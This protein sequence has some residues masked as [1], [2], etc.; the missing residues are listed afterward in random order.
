MKAP[1]L[2]C[3]FLLVY[4]I[5]F[6]QS[7]QIASPAIDSIP[8][9]H[10]REMITKPDVTW[11]SIIIPGTM[12][13]YGV[14]ALNCDWFQDWNESLKDEVWTQNP[15]NLVHIDNYLQWAPAASTFA[16]GFAG[17]KG[18][19]NFTDRALLFGMAELIQSSVVAS[20]KKISGETRPNGESNQSFPSGHTSNAFT[21]AEFMRLEYKNVSPWYGV[22]GY[23][24]AASTGFLRMYNN[25]HW[26]SD[27]L[28]GAGTGILSV[29]FTY[30]IYPK[31]KRLFSSKHT[32]HAIVIPTY[33]NGAMGLTLIRNF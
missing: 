6:A 22:Y 2:I 3:L 16:L 24:V 20:I 25:K 5:A 28:A 21:G 13:A 31:I 33:N 30:Y 7:P 18:R 8:P 19:H 26:L 29:D 14:V 17:I 9:N 15:H 1:S 27:V 12:I 4:S 10:S 23:V 32:L 11:R